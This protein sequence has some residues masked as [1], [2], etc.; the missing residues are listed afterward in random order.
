MKR[1]V[2]AVYETDRLFGGHEE[3]GWWFTVGR[4]VRYEEYD[5]ETAAQRAAEALSGDYPNTGK[6]NSAL[7]GDDWSVMVLDRL[8]EYDVDEYFD[9]SRVAE[10]WPK[11]YPHYE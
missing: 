2:V 7:G 6:R 11:V 1:F 3:G 8:N 10:G 9:G 4:L 5:T